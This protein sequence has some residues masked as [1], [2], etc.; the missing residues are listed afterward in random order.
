MTTC[1]VRK[2]CPVLFNLHI[3]IFYALGVGHTGESECANVCEAT[4]MKVIRMTHMAGMICR[5]CYSCKINIFSSGSLSLLGGRFHIHMIDSLFFLFLL[6][7]P[8]L[9]FQVLCSTEALK[10]LPLCSLGPQK[11]PEVGERAICPLTL[12]KTAVSAVRFLASVL[13]KSQTQECSCRA[14]KSNMGDTSQ[15][16]KPP[17]VPTSFQAG[18]SPIPPH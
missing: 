18:S 10:W 17:L 3:K 13:G 8:I 11:L 6:G 7:N 12:S 15:Q 1:A 16:R 5:E 14:N 4:R 2:L 9:N